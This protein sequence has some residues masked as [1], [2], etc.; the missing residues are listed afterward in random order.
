VAD[1]RPFC[2]ALDGRLKRRRRDEHARDP[3]F[4]ILACDCLALDPNGTNG[5]NCDASGPERMPFGFAL[6]HPVSGG[7]E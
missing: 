1:G 7:V 3:A 4:M 6:D 5:L 2:F